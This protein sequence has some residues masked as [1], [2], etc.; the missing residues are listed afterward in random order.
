MTVI[1]TVETKEI[2]VANAIYGNSQSQVIVL[3][4]A[5]GCFFKYGA[6]DYIKTGSGYSEVAAGGTTVTRIAVGGMS[7]GKGA[8]A[9]GNVVASAIFELQ[10]TSKG[11]LPP[12]MTTAQKNAIGTPAAGLVVYDSSL[13]KLC[14][15]TG[16]AW[17]TITSA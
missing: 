11:F 10:S 4:S 17:E 9:G 2:Q 7:I 3:D 12:R 1:D 5:G 14:V 6:N 15:Y 8:G 13:N 16:A